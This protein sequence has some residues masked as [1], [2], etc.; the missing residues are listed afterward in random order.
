M[1]NFQFNTGKYYPLITIIA[2]TELM[3]AGYTISFESY[4]TMNYIATLIKDEFTCDRPSFLNITIALFS[5]FSSIFR[6]H[7]SDSGDVFNALASGIF[8]ANGS[9]NYYQAIN[10]TNQT[11]KFCSVASFM[12]NIMCSLVCA[13]AALHKPFTLLPNLFKSK[14]ER[15]TAEREPD[16]LAILTK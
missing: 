7:L 1:Q 8:L 14:A 5:I 15:N 16:L 2:T 3:K 12:L 10:D 13:Y 6:Q 9:G 4:I 11:A